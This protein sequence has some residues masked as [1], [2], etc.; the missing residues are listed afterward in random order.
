LVFKKEKK[1]T[2]PYMLWSFR[3]VGPIYRF[4]VTRQYKILP[5]FLMLAEIVKI[6][7][8]N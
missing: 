2:Q 6:T 1:V 4:I 5:K 3:L 7:R 8:G